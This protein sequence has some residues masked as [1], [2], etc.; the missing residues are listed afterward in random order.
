VNITFEN[1][2]LTDS[3]H[4]EHAVSSLR[5]YAALPPLLLHDTRSVTVDFGNGNLLSSGAPAVPNDPL[6]IYGKTTRTFLE[7]MLGRI[8]QDGKTTLETVASDMKVPLDTAR[9]YL[10]NAGRTAG[11]YKVSLPVAPTWNP[12]SGCNE[13]T[14]VESAE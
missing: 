9:A 8:R 4:V 6:T 1:I 3:V 11:A 2:D 5:A 13:Y 7:I 14:L 12:E 10:R